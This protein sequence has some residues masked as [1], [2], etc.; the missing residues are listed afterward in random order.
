[1]LSFYEVWFPLI[2]HRYT[3]LPGAKVSEMKDNWEMGMFI[4]PFLPATWPGS[5]HVL[6]PTQAA[7]AVLQ[8]DS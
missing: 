6:L 1:M 7:E 2:I 3:L 8:C 5:G 4:N